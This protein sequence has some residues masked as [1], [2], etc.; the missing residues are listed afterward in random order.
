MLHIIDSRELSCFTSQQLSIL[1]RE[2]EKDPD[3]SKT[4]YKSLAEQFKVK[5][6]KV[7]KW[8]ADK[9]RKA[10][11]RMM[12]QINSKPNSKRVFKA[13]EG[14]IEDYSALVG[15]VIDMVDHDFSYFKKMYA[16]FSKASDSR[17]VQN[18]HIISTSKFTTLSKGP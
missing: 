5:E 11:N 13:L 17:K 7:Y 10:I 14:P 16:K 3:W 12:H 1:R 4:T 9:K 6:R 15:D 18:K 2:F 8:G